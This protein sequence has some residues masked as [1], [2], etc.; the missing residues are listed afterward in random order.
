[1]ELINKL[2]D[3][4]RSFGNGK[5]TDRWLQ[6][7][8]VI[9]LGLF[10][11]L[12]RIYHI[13]SQS[14]WFDEIFTVL[15][16]R[17]SLMES[18]VILIGDGVHPPLFYFLQRPISL[19]GESHLLVRLPAFIY[20]VFSVVLFYII[21]DKWIGRKCAVLAAIFLAL[22]PF[23]VWY[24][25]DARMYTLLTLLALASMAGY[26][27]FLNRPSFLGN[28]IFV[29]LSC[30]AYLTHYFALFLPLI[31]FA[32]ITINFSRFYPRLRVWTALQIL[33]SVPLIIWVYLLAVRPY[34]Y[35]SIGWI[36][37]PSLR[38][39]LYTLTN[40]TVGFFEPLTIFHWLIIIMCLTL[41]AMGIIN[42]RLDRSFHTL[43]ILWAFLPPVLIFILSYIRPTYVDRFLILSLPPFLMLMVIGLNSIRNRW[44]NILVVF[45][46]LVFSWR[47]LDLLIFSGNLHKEN[48]RQ[49]AEYLA[50][51]VKENEVIVARNIQ[52][53]LPFQY[54]SAGASPI[55]T[56]HE[57][58]LSLSNLYGKYSAAW[59]IYWNMTRDAH[60]LG[61]KAE[62]DIYSE[63][64][65]E[66]FL[67]ITGD[68]PDLID[69]RDFPGLTIFHFN[70]H[71]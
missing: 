6:F 50:E 11:A 43:L 19:L 49:V 23:H 65:H 22:S 17:L 46:M 54:Y 69:R 7:G 34:K 59:L 30:L 5:L 14:L 71:P 70:L 45:L 42:K 24:S 27:T 29:F 53:T 60:A 9:T 40:Y 12:I 28:F 56:M 55:L 39:F 32:H 37:S 63:A 57:D 36:P 48:W 2:I 61:S 18:L 51:N 62:F 38:D 8:L 15:I 4:L 67:W 20:G 47:T 35:F 16:T 58:V 25:Q 33:A 52:T 26:V 41:V 10:S 68:G 31:Q 21:T 64:D 3:S 13:E 44:A 1:M 66:V